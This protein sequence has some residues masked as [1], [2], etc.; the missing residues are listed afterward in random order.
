MGEHRADRIVVGT[1]TR[2]SVVESVNAVAGEPCGWTE[3][4]MSTSHERRQCSHH[5]YVGLAIVG[6]NILECCADGVLED[7]AAIRLAQPLRAVAGSPHRRRAPA[8][9]AQVHNQRRL[10]Q[11]C[12]GAGEVL[13]PL[14]PKACQAARV[15]DS[16]PKVGDEHI[17]A[18]SK[19]TGEAHAGRDRT[20]GTGAVV[21]E[22]VLGV[23]PACVD[24][25][26]EPATP[27]FRVSA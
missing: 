10:W 3:G 14:G 5:T 27:A 17:C 26:H 25:M 15:R 9:E 1:L 16:E 11:K 2:S 12:G 22:G 18:G 24:E 13:L 23:G 8:D 20:R 4:R 19:L 6:S 21:V 7:S